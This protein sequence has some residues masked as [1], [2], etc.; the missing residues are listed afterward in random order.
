MTDHIPVLISQELMGLEMGLQSK[1]D[2]FRV[3]L[4]DHKG[5]GQTK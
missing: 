3:G 5:S 2:L 4:M 1:I